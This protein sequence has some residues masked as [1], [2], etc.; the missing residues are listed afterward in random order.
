M[1]GFRTAGVGCVLGLALTFGLSTVTLR[2]FG[3]DA[4]K[5]R[6]K[7][8]EEAEQRQKFID[9]LN[10]NK[11]ALTLDAATGKTTGPGMNVLSDAT[12]DAQFVLIG[13]DHGMTEI[14]QFM[15]TVFEMLAPR[16][17]HTLAIETGPYVTSAMQEYVSK[18]DGAARMGEFVRKYPFAAAFYNWREEFAFLQ[19][20]ARAG[21]DGNVNLW[22]LDQELMGSAGY[23]LQKI[24]GQKLGPDATAMAERMLKENDAAYA[25]AAKTGDP[26]GLFMMTAKDA[27]LK[28]FGDLLKTQG[29][30][31]ARKMLAAL[32]ESRAIYGKYFAN[33]GYA[34]NRER[35]QLMKQNFRAR[36]EAANDAEPLPKVMFKFGGY[37]MY[38]GLNSLHSSEIGNLVAEL[39]EWN[40]TKSV[41]VM[42]LGVKGETAA[43]GGIGKPSGKEKLDLRTDPRGDFTFLAPML[44]NMLKDSWTMYDVR[45]FRAHFG[46]YGAV[47]KEMERMIFGYDFL[48]LIP[49][50]TASHDLE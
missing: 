40:G 14:P 44:D 24:S 21:K 12:A 17:F 46:S 45:A 30:P 19:R 29:T 18:P 5:P 27:D 43:F 34:S 42:V 9:Q 39:A 20:C 11:Y 22:G 10:K 48:V 2:T 47:D 23:L 49:E 1:R 32:V 4:P 28:A 26:S 41:H 13:E 15:G 50:T 6:D 3:Q 8:K 25:A 37:H 16:G 38:Q 35:A 31:A 36:Y 33:E 7:A